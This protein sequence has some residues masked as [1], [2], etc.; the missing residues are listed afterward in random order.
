MPAGS[1]RESIQVITNRPRLG[2]NGIAGTFSF[3]SV[4]AKAPLRSMSGARLLGV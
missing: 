4:R 3:A 2:M 1:T